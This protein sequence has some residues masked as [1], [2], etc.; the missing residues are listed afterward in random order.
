MLRE[1]HEMVTA[2]IDIGSTMTKIVFLCEDEILGKTVCPTGAEHKRTTY[3]LYRALLEEFNLRED[4]IS[5]IVGT[6]YGRNNVSFADRQ[7]TEITCH[8]AGIAHL[9][10]EARTIIEIGG[11]D[12]KAIKL[13]PNG[14]VADFVM[15]DKCAAGTGRFLQM[16]ADTLDLTL[17]EMNTLAMQAPRDAEVKNYCAILA[18]QEMIAAMS[19]G[20]PMDEIFAGMFVSFA[21]KM[22]KMAAAFRIEDAVV[23]TGGGA[24]HRALRLALEKCLG[25]PV[26]SPQ[27]PFLTGALGAALLA[28][29][30]YLK[31]GKI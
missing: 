13:T 6:G 8:A 9:F 12:S 15:N 4:D 11:Q 10:P 16:M 30:Y 27:E 3:S 25:K 2:G 17:D 18:Q 21:R 1:N 7:V 22:L 14:K 29:K 5:F 19:R 23:L 31:T 24:K 26:L 20:I 28:K